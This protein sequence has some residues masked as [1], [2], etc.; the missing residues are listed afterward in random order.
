MKP[1]NECTDQELQNRIAFGDRI[2]NDLE[3]VGKDPILAP[4]LERQYQ[5]TVSELN[6]RVKGI[7]GD[8]I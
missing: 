6:R 2:K 8:S 1:V 4:H 5:E 7:N 3:K